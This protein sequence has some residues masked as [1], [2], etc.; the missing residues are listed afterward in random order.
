MA[1]QLNL[2]TPLHTSTNRDYLERMNDSKVECMLKAKEYEFDYWDGDRRYGY[3][4]YRYIEGYWTPV[5]EGL[6]E[7]YGLQKGSRILDVGCGKAFLLYELHKLGMDV[8]G[9]D[10]SRHGLA[11]A[12]DEIRDKLFTHRAEEPY[13]Y[14]DGE[15]DLVISINSLHNLPVFNLKKALGEMERVAQNKFLCVESFRNE[16][17]LFNLQCWALTCESFF[18]KEEWTW[19]FKNFSYS[20]DYEFIY[21]E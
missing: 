6:I 13:P 4:G 1:K 18:S 14:A 12:K 15:F 10:I 2:I 19:I 8:H 16:Q 20:G 5:A 9:F 3:G 7:T 17:E 11:G 21:F